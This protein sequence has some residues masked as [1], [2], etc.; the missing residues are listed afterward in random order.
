MSP[1]RSIH[2]AIMAQQIEMPC[3]CRVPTPDYPANA[4]WGPILWSIL[5]GLAE[6]AGSGSI[7][8]DE[9][10][11]WIRFL[12]ETGDMLP[13]DECRAHYVRYSQ[14]N[15]FTQFAKIP[16][17]MLKGAVK[18]WLWQLHAD[19]RTEYGKDVLPY[20]DLT[21]TYGKVNFQDLFWRLEPVIKKTI[22]L[23]GYGLTRWTN[24]IKSFKMLRA[25]LGV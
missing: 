5:H 19:I 23:K 1:L 10:R 16:Y 8:A 20:D 24:W 3:A 18:T 7:P 22:E 12:K 13:C 14:Q 2:R 17:T 21:A 25:T 15:P 4:A 6:R 9:V 11:E